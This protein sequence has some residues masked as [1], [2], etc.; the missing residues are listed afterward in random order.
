MKMTKVT[1]EDEAR[2]KAIDWQSWQQEQSLSY[3]ELSEWQDYFTGLASKFNLTAEF[4]ENG[5]V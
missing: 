4:S 1:T 5:I 2:N 3:S